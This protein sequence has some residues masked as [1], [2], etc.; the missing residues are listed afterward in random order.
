MILL[1]RWFPLRGGYNW[2]SAYAAPAVLYAMIYKTINACRMTDA[3]LK[4]RCTGPLVNAIADYRRPVGKGL[5]AASVD[6]AV[7]AAQAKR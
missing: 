5:F 3:L 1:P 4:E 7:G 6:Q 2:L